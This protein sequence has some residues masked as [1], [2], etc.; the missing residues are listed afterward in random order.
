MVGIGAGRVVKEEAVDLVV[1]GIH[2][3]TGADRFVMGSVAE[4]IFC[5][6]YCPVLTVGPHVARRALSRRQQLGQRATVE[7]NIHTIL[8][9]TDF[10]EESLAAAPFAFSM[11]QESIKP[12]WCCCTCGKRVAKIA[13]KT[14]PGSISW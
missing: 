12:S 14:R 9:P 11:A 5:R 7:S 2:G 4:E 1:L 13:W 10:S 8:Y 3:R 6:A